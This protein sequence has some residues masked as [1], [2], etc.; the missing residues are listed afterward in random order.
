MKR[1]IVEIDQPRSRGWGCSKCA[2]A[3]HTPGSPTGDFYECLLNFWPRLDKKFAAHVCAEH[4]R[5]PRQRSGQ[6][7]WRKIPVTLTD[8]LGQFSVYEIAFVIYQ[9]PAVRSTLDS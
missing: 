9:F 2:W 4:P 6:A 1:E 5:E 8:R 3:F 7:A